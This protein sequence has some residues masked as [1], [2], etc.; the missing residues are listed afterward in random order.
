LKKGSF[1][2][3]IA[4]KISSQIFLGVVSLILILSIASQIFLIACSV[5]FSI[6]L[7]LS[8]LKDTHAPNSA[9]ISFSFTRGRGN[10]TPAERE[11]SKLF[12]PLLSYIFCSSV[13]FALTL[14]GILQLSR[15]NLIPH[16]NKSDTRQMILFHRSPASLEVL[17]SDNSLTIDVKEILFFNTFSLILSFILS[18]PHS[19]NFNNSLYWIF[20]S[21]VV[22]LAEIFPKSKFAK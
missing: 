4:L 16:H 15:F 19:V 3:W 1:S 5:F 13:F 10:C 17:I 18:S 21:F 20:S 8:L 14:I 12:N 9:L 7:I 11:K 2:V 22:K 6:P